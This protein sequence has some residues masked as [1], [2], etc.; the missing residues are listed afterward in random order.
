M[1]KRFLPALLTLILMVTTL[2]N[3]SAKAQSIELLGS[4]VLNGALTGTLLGVGVMG[5]QNSDDFAPMRIG[6]GAGILG[7]TAVALYDI[8][9]LPEG[10]Q[11]FISG[12]FN[13]GNNSSIIILLDTIYG[14]GTGAVL[15]AA[16]MMI[17]NKR[18]IKGFQF[19]GS[20]G[21]WAGFG[22]GLADAFM[23]GERNRDFAASAMLNRSSI[24]ET[25]AG[26]LDID[27]G[28]PT[29]YKTIESGYGLLKYSLNP[30]IKILSIGKNF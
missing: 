23:F 6:L 28:E 21:L 17:Q 14:A 4:N 3:Q 27:I 29:F 5:L 26:A 25:S 2:N 19:G 30:G 22:F 11:F 12:T 13:D 7:G 1:N 18:I 15:G 9:T 8:T 10:Q 16:V 24:F 20:A